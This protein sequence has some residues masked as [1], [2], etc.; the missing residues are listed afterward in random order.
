MYWLSAC[1]S[2]RIWVER[3]V[4]MKVF[5]SWSGTLSH[6]VACVFRDWLP[7]VIQT[8]EPYVSSEDIDKGARWAAD[9][10]KELESSSFGILFI[11]KD[12]TDAPWINFEAGALSKTVDKSRVAPFLFGRKRSEITQGPLLQFQSTVYN[13]SDMTKL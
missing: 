13:R 7:S 10:S 5:L 8:A 12:N 6:A 2:P 1:V 9:I 11:T 3:W 4:L